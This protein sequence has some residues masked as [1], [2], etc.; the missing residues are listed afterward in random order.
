MTPLNEFPMYKIFF[1][2][3]FFIENPVSVRNMPYYRSKMGCM[4]T[5]FWFFIQDRENKTQQEI[6]DLQN[7][8]DK[9]VIHKRNI[10]CIFW[11]NLYSSQNVFDTKYQSKWSLIIK[12][13]T[14]TH[15]HSVPALS[16]CGLYIYIYTVLRFLSLITPNVKHWQC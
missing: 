16:D 11:I 12:K 3:T 4:K 9:K 5:L 8:T 13:H 10:I 7:I 15:T 6:T 14:D 1:F 2:F